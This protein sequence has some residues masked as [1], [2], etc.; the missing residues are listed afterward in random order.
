MIQNSMILCIQESPLLAVRLSG[1]DFGTSVFGH[2]IFVGEAGNEGGP[3]QLE[4]W[5]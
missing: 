4:A 1:T 5:L 3:Y 2:L